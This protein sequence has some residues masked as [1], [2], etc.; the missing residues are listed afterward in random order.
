MF[1][2][3]SDEDPTQRGLGFVPGQVQALDR[4]LGRV[5]NQGWLKVASTGSLGSSFDE[6]RHDYY[7]FSHSFQCSPCDPS[8][9]KAV[10]TSG[11]ETIT[12]VYQHENVIG[13][14]FHPERSGPAGLKLLAHLIHMGV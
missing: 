13:I 14:Q 3:S 10:A 8:V 6:E 7:Y 5:P 1:L 4:E 11:D 9:V 2:D 12:A